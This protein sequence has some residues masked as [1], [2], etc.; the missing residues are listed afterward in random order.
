MIAFSL[1][2]VYS[3]LMGWLRRNANAVTTVV[4]PADVHEPDEA[5]LLATFNPKILQ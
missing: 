3:C 4:T 1:G 5:A 2:N